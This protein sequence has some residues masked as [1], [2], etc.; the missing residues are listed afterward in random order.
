MAHTVKAAKD[1]Q[2][3]IALLKDDS[4]DVILMDIQMPVIDGVETTKAIRG[5]YAG[6]RQEG[7][8]DCCH[9]SLCHR[10]KIGRSF[11]RR[12]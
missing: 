2:E 4:F 8:P 12:A 3:A 5:G 6:R 11:W 7:H 1:G 10:G 9:D